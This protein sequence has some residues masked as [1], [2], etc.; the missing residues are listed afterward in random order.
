[1]SDHQAPAVCADSQQPVT[2]HTPGPWFASRFGDVWAETGVDKPGQR[3]VD[4][5]VMKVDQFE[6]FKPSDQW[7]A[8]A[9]LIAAA[10]DLLAALRLMLDFDYSLDYSGAPSMDAIDAARAA[11][12]AAEGR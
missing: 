4:I 8:N 11:I 6:P 10:P 5:C 7:E 9:R 2:A 3:T 1:M 12:A